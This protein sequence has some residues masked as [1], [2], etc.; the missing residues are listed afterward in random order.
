MGVPGPNALVLSPDG[1]RMAGWVGFRQPL[2]VGTDTAFSYAWT[3][4]PATGPKDHGLVF[5]AIDC[6]LPGVPTTDEPPQAFFAPPVGYCAGQAIPFADAS[7]FGPTAWSWSFPGGEPATSTAPS[8]VVT[9]T[10]PG[11]YAVTLVATNANGESTPYT[12]EVLVDI[13]TGMTTTIADGAW[14]AWP[15]PANGT[16]QVQG[17]SSA[18][19]RVVDLQGRTVWSGT[20]PANG[21]LDIA[22]WAPGS[23]VLLVDA[24]RVRLVKE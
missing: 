23:Y 22:S 16:L 11:T 24:Q 3:P 15:V 14:R 21:T 19:A 8:P 20:L 17:P 18:A 4:P 13:C 12:A 2:V 1:Q 9:Y 5:G 10:V 7:L 6:L